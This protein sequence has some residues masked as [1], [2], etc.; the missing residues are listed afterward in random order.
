MSVSK[1]L[2]LYSRFGRSLVGSGLYEAALPVGETSV[3]LELFAQHRWRVLGGDVYRIDDAD[4]FEPTYD[5]WFCEDKNVEVS[6]SVARSFI[7]NLT[8]RS[9]YIVFVIADDK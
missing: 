9:V 7:A 8:D 5:N 3:V 6:I 4:C 2:E 1:I